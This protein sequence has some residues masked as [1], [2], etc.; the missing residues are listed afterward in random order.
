ME[1][2]KILHTADLHI[3]RQFPG[4][5]GEKGTKRRLEIRDKFDGI[6]N[7]AKKEKVNVVVIAGDLF[8]NNSPSIGSVEFVKEWF[9]KLKYDGIRVFISPGTHDY[10]SPGS[11]WEK[12]EFTDNV[13]IFKSPLVKHIDIPELKLSVYGAAN[14]TGN[15]GRHILKDI[16]L[17]LDH[18]FEKRIIVAHGSVSLP[19]IKTDSYFPITTEEINASQVDYVALGHYHSYYPFDTK[20][21]AA[22]SGSPVLLDLGEK[23][24]K[25]VIMITIKGSSTEV[26]PH[27]IEQN[28]E[29]K[30][31]SVDCSQAYSAEDIIE[32][33]RPFG[34]KRLALVVNLTGVPPINV[35]IESMMRS[36]RRYF[37]EE[38]MF[39][40]VT[41][42]KKIKLPAISKLDEKTAKGIFVG[43]LREKINSA[44]DDE[45]E[46][47]ILALNLGLRALDEGKL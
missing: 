29:L 30:E 22:Y 32:K 31:A 25:Y 17:D 3:D 11:I 13:Y 38:K 24:E 4:F 42:R 1:N 10:I 47:Y 33:I 27:R 40:H 37:E 41:L 6:M 14:E 46:T 5:P 19:W 26:S 8:D 45:R 12:E 23:D 21:K 7:L 43:K 44:A 36:V 15:S 34:N 16:D 39:F 28:Y 35:D 20:V 2:I 18:S 9:K